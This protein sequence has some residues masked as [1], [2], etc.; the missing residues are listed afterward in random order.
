MAHLVLALRSDH[1]ERAGA[2]R[3]GGS[4]VQS[5]RSRFALETSV[6]HAIG[7]VDRKSSGQPVSTWMRSFAA[8]LSI[9]GGDSA[10]YRGRGVHAYE[11][12]GSC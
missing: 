12:Q 9:V 6:A 1:H 10:A 7:L 4:D 5:M 2:R 3:E 8:A 11:A